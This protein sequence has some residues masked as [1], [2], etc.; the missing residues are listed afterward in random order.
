M[1]RDKVGSVGQ[2]RDDGFVCRLVDPFV[3]DQDQGRQKRYAADHTDDHAFGHDHTDVHA[4]GKGHKTKGCETCN[5]RNGTSG[6]GLKG[7]GNC[8]SH[9]SLFVVVKPYLV[10]FIAVEQ[11]DGIIHRHTQLK[12]RRQCLCYVR[13]FSEKD[14]ASQVIQDRDADACQKQDRRQQGF[15]CEAQYRAETSLQR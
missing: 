7:I 14:I 3:K 9:G 5:R 11:E 15:H 4:E 2:I 13:D 8:M 12:N 6:N 1:L 10:I